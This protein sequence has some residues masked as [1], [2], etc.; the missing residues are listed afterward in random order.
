MPQTSSTTKPFVTLKL[1]TTLDGRIAT[2]TGESQWITGA[3]SRLSVHGLR[4]QHDGVLVGIGTALA[5][6]PQLTV[7]GLAL[8]GNS[9]PH[10]II[11]DT[12]LR[13]PPHAQ[14]FEPD[15]GSV[16]VL[17]GLEAAASERRR[18]LEQSGAVIL[19]CQL[20]ADGHVE[21]ESALA[22]LAAQRLTSIFVEGGGSVA[23]A[24]LRARLVDRL[25]WF[26]APLIIGGDGLAAVSSLG[27]DQLLDGIRFK[28]MGVRNSGADIWETYELEA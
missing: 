27:V 5:D 18:V 17:C 19:S 24:F 15:S 23:S 11:L 4:A 3:E 2:R 6:D 10:R 14:V 28:R 26:R 9:Q 1:A 13:L 12:H 7:R 25:E 21:I 20:D 16:F 22:Q 8:P